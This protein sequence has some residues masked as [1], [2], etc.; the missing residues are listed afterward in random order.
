MIASLSASQQAIASHL[1]RVAGCADN[2]ANAETDGYKAKR[3]DIVAD[4]AGNPAAKITIDQRPGPTRHDYNEKG[5]PVEVEMSN[6]DLATEMVNS[7]T[8]ENAIKANLKSIAARDE[9][10]GELIDTLG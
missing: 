10:L 8:S 5:E 1:T 3:V 4:A 2:I 7:M 9:L 6:V